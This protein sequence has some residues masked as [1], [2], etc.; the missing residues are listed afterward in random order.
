MV[1]LGQFHKYDFMIMQVAK[2][3]AIYEP[4]HLQATSTNRLMH[5]KNTIW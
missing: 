3:L 1:S 2:N 5:A 4:W